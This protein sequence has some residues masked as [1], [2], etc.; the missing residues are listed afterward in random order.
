MKTFHKFSGYITDIE[1]GG[2]CCYFKDVTNLEY[3]PSLITFSDELI[4]DIDRK[5]Y[6]EGAYLDFYIRLGKDADSDTTVLRFKKRYWTKEMLAEAEARGKEL[7]E[8]FD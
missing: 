5:W 1:E 2:F 8:L 4:R 7:A 3:P 6:K